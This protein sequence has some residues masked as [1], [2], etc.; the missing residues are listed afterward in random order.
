MRD[1]KIKFAD[2][3]YETE[4]RKNGFNNIAGVDEVGRGC[5]AG[6][7]VVCAL[8]LDMDKFKLEVT[9]SKLLSPKVRQEK[10][11]EIIRAAKALSIISLN[12]NFIDKNN[13]LSAALQAM[14]RAVTS[15]SL[16]AD[17][18]LVD[19]NKIP[20]NLACPASAIVKGDSVSASIAAASIVAKVVRDSMMQR[21]DSF[22][23]DYGFAK[24]LGYPTKV[25]KD[26]LHNFQPIPNLHRF[27]FSPIK[28]LHGF[29]T[30]GKLVSY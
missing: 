2:F 25:H 24:H 17:Y 19:G 5:L 15:L 8:I 6:P 11:L 1:S 23:P 7:V 10:Y 26:A 3:S 4:L 28:Q 29:V 21:V 22:F 14:Q 16:K 18:V 13:I 27:S 12:A 20:E 9:D 30:T